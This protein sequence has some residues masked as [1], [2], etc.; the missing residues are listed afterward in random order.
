MKRYFLF[1]ML[2]LPMLFVACDEDDTVNPN[3]VVIE[4]G[5]AAS[6]EATRD[7]R[8]YVQFSDNE[9]L[10]SISVQLTSNDDGSKLVDITASPADTDYTVDETVTVPETATLGEY[11][12]SM[13]ATDGAGNTNSQTRL[14][15]VT[16]APPA[17]P[18][19]CAPVASCIVD[20]QLTILVTAPTNTGDEDVYIVGSFQGWSPS[21]ANYV[22]TKNPDSPQCYCISVPF[23]PGDGT[24]F[25]FVRGGGWDTV[26][27]TADCEEVDNRTYTDQTDVLEINIAKWADLDGC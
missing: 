21:D 10:S 7:L 11:T 16:E 5:D 25:K 1:L 14:V 9:S 27:K 17:P 23:E 19:P 4:P 15:T 6:V 2:A 24:E 26:E 3:I 12:M 8:A 20:G 22:M 13:T 18:A